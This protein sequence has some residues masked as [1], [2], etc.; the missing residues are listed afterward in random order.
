MVRLPTNACSSRNL[1][2]SGGPVLRE[3]HEVS[4]LIE[5]RARAAVERFPA[6]GDDASERLSMLLYGGAA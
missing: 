2:V 4:Q 1:P 5:T 3:V 6:L